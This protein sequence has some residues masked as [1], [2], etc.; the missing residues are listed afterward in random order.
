MPHTDCRRACRRSR[1]AEHTRTHDRCDDRRRPGPRCPTNL[2]RLHTIAELAH[3][4]DTNPLWDE[5][6]SYLHPAASAHS[7][8]NRYL[9]VREK[10]NTVPLTDADT[11][12]SWA[13]VRT[14]QDVARRRK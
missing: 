10:R 7:F 2:D 14:Q 5:V 6:V 1:T 4:P 3:F 12:A 9:E 13:L 11:L 8:V